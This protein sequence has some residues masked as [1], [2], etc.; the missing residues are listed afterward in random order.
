MLSVRMMFCNLLNH[1]KCILKIL[2]F[3][4]L[5]L[6]NLDDAYKFSLLTFMHGYF[7]DNLSS[8]CY[9]FKSLAEPN[10]TKLYKLEKVL[11]KSQKASHPP[12]FQNCGIQ[13]KKTLKK[14][15]VNQYLSRE[16]NNNDKHVFQKFL[17]KYNLFTFYQIFFHPIV[18]L[19]C[20]KS[21]ANKNLEILSETSI[22]PYP[23]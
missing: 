10:R 2:L 16:N 13:L 17:K 9:M 21:K 5:K 1:K 20:L 18:F 14:L 4:K 12:C 11:N 23:P 6:L 19:F 15:K 22:I 3:S 7:N 8:S